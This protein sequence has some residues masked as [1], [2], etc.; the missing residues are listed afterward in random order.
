MSRSTDIA[1][2]QRD[3]ALTELEHLREVNRDLIGELF[4]ALETAEAEC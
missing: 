2:E 3:E 1:R 4:V